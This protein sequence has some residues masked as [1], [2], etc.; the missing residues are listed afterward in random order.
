MCVT[1]PAE[2]VDCWWV[3]GSP[4]AGFCVPLSRSC[5]A[6]DLRYGSRHRRDPRSRSLR[7]PCPARTFFSPDQTFSNREVEWPS[8]RT[9]TTKASRAPSVKFDSNLLRYIEL[10][11]V[12]HIA[13]QESYVSIRG[14]VIVNS[15]HSHEPG[16]LVSFFRRVPRPQRT[17]GAGVIALR[18]T[19][20]D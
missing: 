3:W 5:E 15:D 12:K 14:P 7:R 16:P 4:R 2:F 13:H 10:P 19:V 9:L 20:R 11:C 17:H 8:V 18:F 1:T 6:P